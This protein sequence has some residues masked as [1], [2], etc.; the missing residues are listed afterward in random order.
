MKTIALRQFLLLTKFK[1]CTVLP[2]NIMAFYEED[3]LHCY[4]S[5]TSKFCLTATYRCL[6]FELYFWNSPKLLA[7]V[8]LFS[9]IMTITW[10]FAWLLS[11]HTGAGLLFGSGNCA[12]RESPIYTQTAF[13]HLCAF[14]CAHAGACARGGSG[15]IR[16]LVRTSAHWRWRRRDG[17][18][19]SPARTVCYLMPPTFLQR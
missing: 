5:I 6:C 12:K 15:E 17:S 4:R 1:I 19:R 7:V 2:S 13:L 9:R 14:V 11:L 18:P 3:E 8:G 10:R 16:Y